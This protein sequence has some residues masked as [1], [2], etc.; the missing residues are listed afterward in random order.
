MCS[1]GPCDYQQRASIGALGFKI[2]Q[3]VIVAMDSI[4]KT[5]VAEM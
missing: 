2:M 3:Q 5:L 1:K 4:L